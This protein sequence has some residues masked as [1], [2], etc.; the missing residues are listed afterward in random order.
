MTLKDIT[1]YVIYLLL[2]LLQKYFVLQHSVKNQIYRT[3]FFYILIET[4]YIT[5]S[6][7]LTSINEIKDYIKQVFAIVTQGNNLLIVLIQE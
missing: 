3:L 4:A 1:G 2:Y 6:Y 7:V 5:C